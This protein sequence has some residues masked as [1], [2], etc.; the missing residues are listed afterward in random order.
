VQSCGAVSRYN[1]DRYD[2][3]IQIKKSIFFESDKVII[4]DNSKNKIL[5]NYSLQAGQS[6][7]RYRFYRSLKL[8][9]NFCSGQV[10]LLE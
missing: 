3:D 4:L 10:C 9:T 7:E 2:T 6:M 5:F 1:K 8:V